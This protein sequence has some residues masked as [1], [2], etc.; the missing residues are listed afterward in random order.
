MNAQSER[1]ADIERDYLTVTETAARLGSSDRAVLKWIKQ[2]YFPGTIR[3][4]PTGPYRIPMVAI[5]QYEK[6]RRVS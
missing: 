1:P 4:S 3:I 2:G 6:N 5:E